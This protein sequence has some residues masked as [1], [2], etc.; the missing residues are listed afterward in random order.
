MA[1]AKK[2]V[3]LL[4]HVHEIAGA[5]SEKLIGVYETAELAKQAIQRLATK[6]GFIATPNGFLYERY[7]LNRD[8][9]TEGFVDA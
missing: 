3:F 8:H 4:W 7:D 2:S 6:P 9:W 1:V 5:D